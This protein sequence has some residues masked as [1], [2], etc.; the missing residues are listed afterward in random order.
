[1]ATVIDFG[2]RAVA[3]LRARV[4]AVEED[5]QDLLAFAS[6]HAGAVSAIHLAAL[7]LIDGDTLPDLVGAVTQR[8]P[9]ILGLDAIAL[10]AT[11]PIGSIH[12][13]GLGYR[14]VEPRLIGRILGPL[15][16]VIVR[17]VDRGHPIFG[18]AA[19]QVRA[20]ALIRIDAAGV[21]GLLALGQAA[22]QAFESDAGAELLGF[23]G[24]VIARMM[25]RCQ[26]QR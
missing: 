9:A 13:H 18:G 7:E 25:A 23:L 22:P 12:A 16:A 3:T 8:W 4:A 17:N 14:V 21:S 2:E 1:M 19:E 20:E 6:G 26:P 11:A 10:A 24:D 5:V 15:P